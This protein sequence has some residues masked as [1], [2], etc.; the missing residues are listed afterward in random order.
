M[1]A[2]LHH[3]PPAATMDHDDAGQTPEL[4]SN[5][6]RVGF[7]VAEFVLDFGR[8][9]DG[10]DRFYQRVITAPVHAKELSRLLH[11][12]VRSYEERFGLIAGDEEVSE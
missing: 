5:H 4:Y 10:D 6:F 9:F 3:S 7:N 8:N 12:S 1:A 2:C 11:E